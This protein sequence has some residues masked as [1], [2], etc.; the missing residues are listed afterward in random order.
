VSLRG[1]Y[2]DAYVTHDLGDGRPRLGHFIDIV[3]ATP[4]GWQ[5]L[6]WP[7]PLEE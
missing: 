7:G 1:H 3:A 2:Q 4:E 5:V 6:G